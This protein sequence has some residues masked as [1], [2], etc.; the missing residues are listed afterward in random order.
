MPVPDII[1]CL[2]V[3]APAEPVLIGQQEPVNGF[4]LFRLPNSKSILG[5]QVEF[6]CDI[7]CFG[8]DNNNKNIMKLC[9]K[10]LTNFI[11]YLIKSMP[12]LV[13]K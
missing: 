11:I 4:Q 12:S 1:V 3:E 6:C 2:P 9:D 7:N 5:G 13:L 10:K 8:I